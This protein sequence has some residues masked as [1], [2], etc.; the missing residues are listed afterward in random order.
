[1]FHRFDFDKILMVKTHGGFC[2]DAEMNKHTEHIHIGECEGEFIGIAPEG[3]HI[4]ELR[5]GG[6]V[7][8]VHE[9]GVVFHEDFA[10]VN[11]F[12]QLCEHGSCGYAGRSVVYAFGDGLDDKERSPSTLSQKTRRISKVESRISSKLLSVTWISPSFIGN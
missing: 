6:D 7:E 5:I 12:L 10:D 11:R 1:M 8:L 9:H 2:D 3:I 4:H